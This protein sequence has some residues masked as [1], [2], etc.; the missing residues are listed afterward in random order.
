MIM[1][2]HES[3]Q[4]L[5][6]LKSA[7]EPVKDPNFAKIRADHPSAP[8]EGVEGLIQYM[9]LTAVM[10]YAE[11]LRKLI[12]PLP[13]NDAWKEMG[14][15][16]TLEIAAAPCTFKAYSPPG[17]WN[18]PEHIQDMEQQIKDFKND[19]RNK[20]IYFKPSSKSDGEVFRFSCSPTLT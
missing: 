11:G 10:K 16:K 9:A 12:E 14:C 4:I 19:D 2:K 5:K 3:G 6:L 15:P 7:I 20:A 8:E 1:T 13:C 18:M 17:K